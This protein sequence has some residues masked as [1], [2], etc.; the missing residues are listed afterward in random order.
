MISEKVSK[1]LIKEIIGSELHTA[2]FR[3]SLL[4]SQFSSELSTEP[5]AGGQES[6]TTG[7]KSLITPLYGLQIDRT[8]RLTT[9]LGSC[10]AFPNMI[11]TLSSDKRF[12]DEDL[13][14]NNCDKRV[15]ERLSGKY[16]YFCRDK[17]I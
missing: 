11:T 15:K 1:Q 10:G 8:L 3:K 14:Y 12:C 9:C 13:E 16:W 2:R 7:D 6:H 5:A 4:H 17:R